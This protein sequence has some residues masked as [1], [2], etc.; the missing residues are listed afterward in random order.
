MTVPMPRVAGARLASPDERRFRSLVESSLDSVTIIEPD[1]TIAYA[2]PAYARISGL[3][4]EAAV[5]TNALER[6][7]PDDR[8]RAES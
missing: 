5:G 2:S 4:P 1:G 6:I 7:H 8:A 3:R